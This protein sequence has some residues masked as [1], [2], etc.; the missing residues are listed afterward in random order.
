ML[1]N[2]IN[3]EA[4]IKETFINRKVILP[5]TRFLKQGVEPKKLALAVTIGVTVGIFPVLGSTTLLCAIAAF[6]LRLNQP[7]VQLINY[8]V[9]PLQFLLILPFIKIGAF[10]LNA[11]PTGY[12][13]SNIVTMFQHNLFQAIATLWSS[14]L[15]AV[16]A[17]SCTAP[18]LGIIIYFSL[19]PVFKKLSLNKT[20]SL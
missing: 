16:L 3:P 15:Y 17:W 11:P 19:I 4:Q 13:I 10:F 18:L 5:L 1:E 7:A 12:S 8:F 14:L 2:T 20:K 6:A 9:Y